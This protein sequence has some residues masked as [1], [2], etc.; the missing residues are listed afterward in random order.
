MRKIME[1]PKRHI[2]LGKTELNLEK[3]KTIKNRIGFVK[4]EGGLWASPYN[5]YKEYISGWH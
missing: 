5:P 4:P 2:I 3:F 1:M